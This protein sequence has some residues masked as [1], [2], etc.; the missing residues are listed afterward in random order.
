MKLVNSSCHVAIVTHDSLRKC[1]VAQLDTIKMFH[2]DT[3]AA[4]FDL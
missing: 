4:G 3:I 1:Y 2:N